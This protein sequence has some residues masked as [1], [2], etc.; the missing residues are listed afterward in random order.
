MSRLS[1][2]LP[3]SFKGIP[4]F[5]R[6]EIQ[7]EAGRRVILHDYPNSSTRYVEDLGQMPPKFS[8]TAFVTGPDFLNRSDQLER[9]LQ[10]QGAG[11]L[12]MP[13]FGVVTVFALPYR[14]DASQT[15]VGEIRFELSFAAGRAISG[16]IRAPGTI[17]KVYK[18]GDTARNEL[19]N[20][21]ER[22]WTEPTETSNVLTAIFDLK[23]MAKSIESLNT[24]INN[25]ADINTLLGFMDINAPSIVRDANYL[26][27][28]VTQLWQ[29]VSL[30]LSGGAGLTTLLGLTRFGSL[31]TLSLSDIRSA[32]ISGTSTDAMETEIPL[33]PPTTAGRII[34]DD[35]R[36]ELVNTHRVNALICA[37]EQ[38]ADGSYQT[39]AEL[40]AARLALENEHERLMRDDTENRDLVQSQAEVRR[41]VEDLRLAA[42]D[43]L[44]QKDQSTF[45]LT[46]MSLNAPLSCFQ[47]AYALYAEQFTES[48]QVSDQ[49]IILRGLNPL[50]PSDKMVG[51][52]SVLQS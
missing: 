44:D 12:S 27:F 45:T 5:V 40:D 11:K 29:T 16:P 46:T 42:I 13:T 30:G 26:K 21:L 18:R 23:Q 51:E 17:E 2:L 41:A 25:T 7:T 50:Q 49:A 28:Q 20:A 43:V 33:W 32:D 9:A 37:Y 1:N 6:N 35:N 3:A 36:L 31:L 19:G 15:A 47:L 8:V 22:K 48:G 52:I 38:A 34:R 24:V 14:K 4:F 39:D 10:E